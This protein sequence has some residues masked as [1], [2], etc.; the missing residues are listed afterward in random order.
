MPLTDLGYERPTY[1][2]LLEMQI[3]RAKLLFGNDID[4]SQNTA[5]GK[6]IRLNVQ[7]YAD[8][9][10]ENE[11]LYYSRFPHTARGISLDR[12]C[13]F[14][15]IARNP[16]T[17][18]IHRMRFIGTAGEIVPAAF[19][20]STA[21][22]T[23]LY[24]T[25]ESYT[26]GED[27]TAEGLVYCETAGKVG[28]VATGKID[29]IV[30]PDVNV[31]SI[32]HLGIA[33]YADDTETD[34]ALRKR[35]DNT[36]SGAGSESYTAIKAAILQVP[37]VK[38]AEV[39]END[40]DETV[41]GI[42]PHSFK[43]YVLAPATQD[44]LVAEAIYSKKPIGIRPVGDVSVDFVDKYGISRTIAFSRT[45]EKKLYIKM[46][47]TKNQYFE[48]DGVEQI[49]TAIAEYINNL[50][51]GE[52]VYISSIYGYIYKAAGV[53]NVA[54]LTMSTD[55]STYSA[56]NVTVGIGEVARIDTANI[57]VVANG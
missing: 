44:M 46:Q 23:L 45:A 21:D 38:G 15:G 27:G 41:D 56:G 10:E 42:P 19:E 3:E 37:S 16:A 7:D 49:Q 18:A 50:V 9:Y 31:E 22:G 47:I 24:H 39:V 51:N 53:V 57:E 32:V 26:M 33:E 43:C 20:V 5:L 17:Y 54:S 28:N 29:T 14:V 8:I 4:T 11:N 36:L 2:E 12:L 35:W 25:Y 30:N 55:G 6:Y 13:P 40:K 1:D 48:A 52:D 34:V